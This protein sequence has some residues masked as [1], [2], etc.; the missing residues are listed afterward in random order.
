MLYILFFAKKLARVTGVSIGTWM[1]L[2]RSYDEKMLEIKR[3]K[4]VN[5][6]TSGAPFP[7]GFVLHPKYQM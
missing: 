5:A 2:Q 6:P 4:T 3:A 1:N 7:S